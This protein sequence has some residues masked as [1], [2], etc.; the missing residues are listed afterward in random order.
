MQFE[1]EVNG[2]LRRVTVHRLA[3]GFQVD[4]DGRSYLVDA[5]RVGDR[6]LSLLQALGSQPDPAGGASHDVTFTPRPSGQ[7]D[8]YFGGPPVTVSINGR[9]RR[10]G[11]DAPQEDG[12]DRVLAPMPGKIVRLLVKVG[13]TVSA[14]RP[15][16]VMEAM[17]ME[18]ELR[19]RRDGVVTAVQV[20]EGESVDAGAVLVVVGDPPKTADR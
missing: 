18:N 13:D 12:P 14:K 19:A 8:V 7:V 2:K 11:S 17:K 6:T 9:R 10:R 3:R 1:A 5:E 15:L 16:V 20:R 4:V